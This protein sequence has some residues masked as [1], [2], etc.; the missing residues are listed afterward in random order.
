MPP[1]CR[2][3]APHPGVRGRSH[4]SFRREPRRHLYSTSLPPRDTRDM[5][6]RG[7]RFASGT[8]HAGTSAKMAEMGPRSWRVK[9]HVTSICFAIALVPFCNTSAASAASSV[10]TVHTFVQT[11]PFELSVLPARCKVTPGQ[12]AA[13]DLRPS[14]V[15]QSGGKIEVVA[16]ARRGISESSL[17]LQEIVLDAH[18]GNCFYSDHLRQ[19]GAVAQV[20]LGFRPSDPRM[21]PHAVA[22]F[23]RA[24][25]YEFSSVTESR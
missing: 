22:R 8:A 10:H 23:L 1:W 24:Q 14:V 19:H 16:T 7:K 6:E 13:S 3:V 12:K 4:P 20:Q 17:F 21:D 2:G 9:R 15:R 5:F 18:D 25:K 11:I